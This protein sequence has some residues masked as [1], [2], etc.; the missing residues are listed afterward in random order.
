LVS[1]DAVSG[2]QKCCKIRLWP[3]IC[4]D[5]AGKAYSFPLDPLAV[6]KGAYFQGKGTGRES[7]GGEEK[8]GEAFPKQKFTT[9]PLHVKVYR[10]ELI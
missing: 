5:P 7:R 10:V 2:V 3:R 6:L 8:G 9:T 4:L 1:S